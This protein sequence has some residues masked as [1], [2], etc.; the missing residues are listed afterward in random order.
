MSFKLATP[1]LA[2]GGKIKIFMRNKADKLAFIDLLKVSDDSDVFVSVTQK[3][4]FTDDK[5]RDILTC[6]IDKQGQRFVCQISGKFYD[7]MVETELVL[8]EG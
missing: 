8:R 5:G 2:N 7:W 4:V 3:K 1:I 6:E